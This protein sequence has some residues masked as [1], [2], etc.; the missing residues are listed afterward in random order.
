LVIARKET[1][2]IN[3]MSRIGKKAIK[4]PEKTEASLSGSLL[5][6]KGPLG[7]MTREIPR[8]I[9]LSIENGEIKL[10]PLKTDKN[11]NV[12]IWG[13]TASHV[14]NM[15]RGVTNGFEKKLSIEG[16]GYKAE[17]KGEKLVLALGFSHPVEVAIPK[18]ISV[19]VEKNLLTVSGVDNDQVGRFS[20]FVRSLKKPEP[21]KGKGI[22]YENEVVKIKQ[23]KKT[24]A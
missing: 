21:Y 6:V 5:T 16:I 11:N 12:P 24:V 18:G 3:T 10:T 1:D 4:I 15:V 23:G 9:I 7:E 19:K 13:T 20:A 14:T 2:F 8:N 17:L 22:R